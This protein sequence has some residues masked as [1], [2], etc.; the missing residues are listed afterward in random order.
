MSFR[1]RLIVMSA[2]AVTVAIALVASTVYVLVRAQLYNELDRSLKDRTAQATYV[3]NLSSPTHCNV[4]LT[5][6]LAGRLG[7]TTR[8]S[9]RPAMY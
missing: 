2:L 3:K 8:R 1:L 9:P 4:N 6:S 5:S 7:G